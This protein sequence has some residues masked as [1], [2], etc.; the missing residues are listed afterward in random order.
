VFERTSTAAAPWTLVEG[1]DKHWARVKVAETVR[2]RL[3]VE[4]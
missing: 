4:W 2:D 3:A 1:N